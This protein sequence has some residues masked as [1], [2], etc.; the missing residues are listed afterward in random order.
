MVLLLV[1]L[2]WGLCWGGERR[3]G[4]GERDV[5]DAERS[6]TALRHRTTEVRQRP[7]NRQHA[8]A[9]GRFGC[10]AS[11]CCCCCCCCGRCGCCIHAAHVGAV[12]GAIEKA[13]ATT[14]AATATTAT[15]DAA[16]VGKGGGAAVLHHHHVRAS[17][18]RCL[19]RWALH[20]MH[21]PLNVACEGGGL[22]LPAETLHRNAVPVNEK[23][24]KVVLD[25][26][27]VW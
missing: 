27:A 26:D 19:L 20:R 3:H 10:P 6:L 12:A 13:Q 23:Q 22:R 11:C 25:K 14:T 17:A 15:R 21:Q 16:R 18:M 9:L 8:T 24:L 2:V 1:L 4:A 7:V 5:C